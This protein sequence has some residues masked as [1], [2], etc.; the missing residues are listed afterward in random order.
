MKTPYRITHIL[1]SSLFMLIVLLCFPSPVRADTFVV[2]T[3]DDTDDGTCNSS[4]C[5]FREA[6]FSANANPGP[7]TISFAGLDA[8]NG[9]III[10]LNSHLG[11]WT[12]DA[13]TIDGTTVLGYQSEPLINILDGQGSL[14]AAISL[15]SDNNVIRGLSIAGFGIFPPGVDPDPGGYVGGAILVWGSG[16]VIENNELGWGALNNSIGLLLDGAGNTASGNLISGNGIGIYIDEPG[17]TILNNKIGTDASGAS[18]N[19]N[20]YGIYDHKGSGGGHVIG[21]PGAGNVISGN[22]YGIFLLA[23]GTTV[24]GNFIGTDA[25][26]TSDVGNGLGMYL[27]GANYLIGGSGSGEGNLI[28]GNGRGI[29]AIADCTGSQ[30]LGNKIGSDITGSALLG[31]TNQGIRLFG[32]GVTIGGLNPGEGNLFAGNWIGI[33][34]EG[35]TNDP[36]LGNTITRNDIGVLTFIDSGVSGLLISQNSIFDNNGLGIQTN[37]AGPDDYPEPPVLLDVSNT[38]VHGNTCSLCTVEIFLAD[39]DPT[40]AGEGKTFLGSVLSNGAGDFTLNITLPQPQMMCQPLTAT[41]TDGQY[42]TSEFSQ[43][44]L[45]NCKK[46]QPP[47]LWPLWTFI[48]GLFVLGGFL[49]R[50]VFPWKPAFTLPLSLI[51]GIAAGG[52]LLL[53]A[54]QLPGVIVDFTPDEQVLYSGQLPNCDTY[55]DPQG[56]TPADG[57]ILEPASDIT[58]SWTPSGNLPDGEIQWQIKLDSSTGLG[59]TAVTGSTSLSLSTMGVSAMQSDS[60][61]WA[62]SGQKLLPDG[63]TWLPFCAPGEPLTFQILPMEE[64]TE[65]VE[66]E[67][68]EEPTAAPTEEPAITEEPEDCEP[69]V[70]ALM[71]LNCRVGPGTAFQNVGTLLT[72][73][74][75]LVDGQNSAG[76]WVWIL[77]PDALGHCWVWREGVEEVCM[78]AR[79]QIIAEP[80]LEPESTCRSDLSR[81]ECGDA[82]GIYDPGADPP[83]CNCP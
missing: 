29:H 70:T 61:Q 79:L 18:I 64:E 30:I 35:G 62:V 37:F 11:M 40:G 32:T 60:Y 7:D 54:N 52:G 82:G 20:G 33:D 66:E 36:V 43:N 1:G 28:S 14:E 51:V 55:L 27:S 42:N 68:V 38:N 74:S 69:T 34:L 21:S 46:L 58:L 24:Q 44:L 39:P 65:E 25:S 48:T 6:M 78:P 22:S 80:T 75:A 53:L 31:N 5:S 13:T 45:L 81:S 63:E 73:E 76:T 49:L 12:D 47:W 77:N 72:G 15:G 59:G 50:K 3:P 10:T 23:G 57:A 19:P 67:I 56:F 17:Q 9:D 41:V 16:N 8:T 4:H 2:N 71:D 83:M 26:G